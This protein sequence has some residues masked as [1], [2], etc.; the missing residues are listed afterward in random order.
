MWKRS[1]RLNIRLICVII[2]LRWRVFGWEDGNCVNSGRSV[3]YGRPIIY[4]GV[5]GGTAAGNSG[6]FWRENECTFSRLSVY[7]HYIIGRLNFIAWY[8]KSCMGSNLPATDEENLR[9]IV[10]NSPYWFVLYQ[11]QGSTRIGLY[12]PLACS[13]S[14]IYLWFIR[15]TIA[16]VSASGYSHRLFTV[17]TRQSN[18]Y[19]SGYKRMQFPVFSPVQYCIACSQPNASNW[20]II[21]LNSAKKGRFVHGSLW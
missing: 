2:G 20:P 9:V 5:F 13:A 16:E 21:E 19:A 7:M 18:Y 14:V 10:L 3:I 6:D 4:G 11:M 15:W 8:L 12:L 17:H 1:K